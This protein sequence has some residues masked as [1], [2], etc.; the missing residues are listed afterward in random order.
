M[1][2]ALKSSVRSL[3]PNLALQWRAYH[4][5][6][7]NKNSYLYLSGWMDSLDQ[8]KPMDHEGNL[9][10]W[11]NFGI[12]NFLDDRLKKDLTIYEY[13]S[14]FST[15]YYAERT[16]QVTSVEHDKC[17]Y[18]HVVKD[19]PDNVTL[20]YR[21]H[22][23][24]GQYCSSVKESEQAYDLIMVDGRDRVNCVKQAI[25][26]LTPRGV[27]ML[28]DSQR[29]KYQDVFPFM[30][31]HGFRVLHFEGMKPKGTGLNRTSIFY[32]DV[33]CLGI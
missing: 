5:L 7:R 2:F 22:D 30:A 1:K 12:V 27:V 19:M 6:I 9:I 17:W 32:R 16:Q 33:N 23:E 20:L 21:A 18:E 25:H 4:R 8:G 28:D 26:A 10:P 31:Q 24:N 13:G 29:E 15:R 11:L 3:L 14:G